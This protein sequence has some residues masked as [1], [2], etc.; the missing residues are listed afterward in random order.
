MM[1]CHSDIETRPMKLKEIAEAA[2]N[3]PGTRVKITT[4]SMRDA[5]GSMVYTE[6]LTDAQMLAYW[7]RTVVKTVSAENTVYCVII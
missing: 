3:R 7:E 2:K 4:P 5:T 6:A 1:N